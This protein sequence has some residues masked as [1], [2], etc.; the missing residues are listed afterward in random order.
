MAGGRPTDFSDVIAE[1]I[2]D[3]IATTDKG[4]EAICRADDSLPEPRTVYRW[5]YK[6]HEFCQKYNDAKQSQTFLMAEQ[7]LAIAD[8]TSRDTIESEHGEQPDSE[9]IARSKLR[10]DTRKWL[11]SKLAPKKYGEKLDLNHGG[12]IQSVHMTREQWKERMADVAKQ[13]SLGTGES[14]ASE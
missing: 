10:V 4:L 12:T 13:K 9:W 11:M 5:L 3:A 8:D 7:V 14:V 1:T 6:N 2:C